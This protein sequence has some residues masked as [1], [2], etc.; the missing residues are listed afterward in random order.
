[1]A[2]TL[3]DRAHREHAGSPIWRSLSLRLSAVFTA[4]LIAAA[5]A[6]GYL[7][8]RGR[9]EALEQRH[10]EHLQRHAEGAANEVE[11][12]VR[13]LEED[14]LFLAD[15]PPVQGIRRAT[16]SG[17]YD[18]LGDSSLAQWQERLQHIFLAFAE[19]KPEYF[20]LRLIGAAD[21]GRE[22]VRVEQ[23]PDAQRVTPPGDL[24]R[25]G[26][27]YYFR[28]ASRLK[29]DGVYL[30]RID[31]NREHG[32]IA[33]PHRP[34]LRA[35]TPVHDPRGRLFGVVVVNMD[36]AHAFARAQTLENGGR[37]LY[38][39]NEKG[40]FLLHPTPGR[41]F[42]GDLGS[43]FRLDDAFAGHGHDIAS[44][45]ADRGSFIEMTRLPEPRVAYVTA[46]SWDARN[47]DRLLRFITT[48]P[49]GALTETVG[50]MRRESMIGVGG[51]L[52]LAVGLVAATVNRATR[53]LGQLATASEA[54]ARG[55]YAVSLPRGGASEV[56]RLA[57]AFQR[58]AEEVQRREEALARLN[59]DLERR[60]RE[61]TRELSR[62]HDTQ[63]L[64]L[65][66]IADGVVVTDDDGRFILWNRKAEQ[67]V[68]S[69]PDTIP[70]DRWP[71]HF[72]VFRDESEEPVA[73]QDLP[74]VRAMRGESTVNTELYLRHP[75]RSVGR[76]TQVTAR[77][78]R[79]AKGDVAGAV[80]VLLD[81]TEQKRLQ[82]RLL[83]HRAELVGLGRRILGAEIASAAAHQLSQPIAA[84]CNYAGAAARLQEQGR[85]EDGE[86]RNILAR[87][88]HLSAR[89]GEILGRLRA[90]IRRRE[91][92][93][94][95]FEL[96][97]VLSS[98]LDF[99]RERID[100]QGVRVERRYGADLPALQGDPLELEHALIQLVSNALDAM[101]SKPRG[102]RRLTVSSYLDGRGERAVA[103]IADT[104]PGVSPEVAERMFEPW[105]TSRPGALGIGLT[106]AQT[107]VEGLGGRI[108]LETSAREGANFLLELPVLGRKGT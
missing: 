82:G 24:Q 84:I 43:S 79:D 27:R 32:R 92:A 44:T 38:V 2:L 104:G 1:M 18:A 36:M 71:A 30:S 13:R 47:P 63:R 77:P 93:A 80:A 58:M 5:V 91:P 45:A 105:E 22:L 61:R 21:G 33:T 40:D 87:M 16:E 42:A 15:T 53:S 94:T 11:R 60:V 78:L 12:F 20:Q 107:I 46:R 19:A 8:D 34:T 99:L 50:W 31:L 89:A 69:G 100:R 102:E 75:S 86:L 7:F 72:G 83:A 54:V 25:K 103:A 6:V 41:A 4:L 9:A 70:P 17:G 51:L 90:L 23:A 97:P 56:Q 35:A 74:L 106:I 66:N 14:V 26:E 29:T 65:D 48:E 68:G 52:L 101:E 3:P 81:V 95:I 28:E 108:R 10:L 98:C 85:L 49:I 39:V 73:V 59:Q 37:S 55:A 96:N 62:Q 57:A 76:W 67:I 88:E 64:I